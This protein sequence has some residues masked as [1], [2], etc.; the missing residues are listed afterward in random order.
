[1]LKQ[2]NFRAKSMNCYAKSMN[3]NAKSMTFHTKIIK[4]F[5]K[6]CATETIFST[7]FNIQLKPVS[8]LKCQ[9]CVEM[10]FIDLEKMIIDDTWRSISSSSP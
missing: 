5:H 6:I 4:F 8:Y 2:S 7:S 3:S 1:M 9:L 10:I